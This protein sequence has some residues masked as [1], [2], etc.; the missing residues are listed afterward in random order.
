MHMCTYVHLTFNCLCVCR[1]WLKGPTLAIIVGLPNVI[2]LWPSQCGLFHFNNPFWTSVRIQEVMT[3]A[4]IHIHCLAFV[5]A[6]SLVGQLSVS[7]LPQQTIRLFVPETYI[8]EATLWMLS[9]DL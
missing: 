8:F 5:R 9:R 2:N 6:A 4:Q 7:E 1:L 3:W